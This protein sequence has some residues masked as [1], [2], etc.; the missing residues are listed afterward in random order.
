ML[1]LR[2]ENF[3]IKLIKVLKNLTCVNYHTETQKFQ[4]QHVSGKYV[5]AA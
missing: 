4:T 2:L 3:V 5:C 1:D